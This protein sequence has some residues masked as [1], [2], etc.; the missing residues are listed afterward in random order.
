MWILPRFRSQPTILHRPD[1]SSARVVVDF[2][3]L[4]AGFHPVDDT[5][6]GSMM[7][8]LSSV[9]LL[10]SVVPQP[11]ERVSTSRRTLTL[12]PL[13]RAMTSNSSSFTWFE[14]LKTKCHPKVRYRGRALSRRRSHRRSRD[15]P[16]E[17]TLDQDSPGIVF[18]HRPSDLD[19]SSSV[20]R[21]DLKSALVR[22][23][24]C[25]LPEMLSKSAFA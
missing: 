9:Q 7:L 12:T 3:A 1:R 8:H 19:Q 20:F 22:Q 25:G 5:G 24:G 4:G 16:R 15:P 11:S 14:I 13:D 17:N 23:A 6:K 2:F 21:L 18:V 10:R